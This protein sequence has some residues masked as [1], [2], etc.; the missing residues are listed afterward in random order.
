M[1]GFGKQLVSEQSKTTYQIVNSKGQ[2]LMSCDDKAKVDEH[3]K[4]LSERMKE[5]L[6]VKEMRCL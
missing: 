2:V 4:I 3:R 6:A 1:P 5:E